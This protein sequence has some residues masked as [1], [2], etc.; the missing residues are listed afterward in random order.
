MMKISGQ[1]VS[2]MEIEECVLAVPG[3]ADAAVVGS[4]NEDGLSRAV[5]F[6]EPARGVDA[7]LLDASVLKHL[8]ERLPP[9]K[10]PRIR[11]FIEA[12]PRTG[13]G[14]LQ[15]FELRRLLADA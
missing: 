3:V 7:D 1:W 11:R 2:P 13:T 12:M 14:K 10:R 5:L 4:A 15:R 6:V 8:S 9:Y